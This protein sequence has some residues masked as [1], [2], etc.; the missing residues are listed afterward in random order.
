VR[1]ARNLADQASAAAAEASLNVERLRSSSAAIGSVVEVISKIAKQTTLLALNSTIEAAR[2]G[3]SGRGF[4]VVA[5]EVKA[6]AVQTQDATEEIRKKIEALQR[7][8]VASFEAVHRISSAINSIRPVFENVNTAVA[9]QSSVTADMVGNAAS[10][11]QFIASVSGSAIEIDGVTREAETHGVN[12][13]EV[14]QTV[15]QFAE[16]LKSRCAILLGR[17][18]SDDQ[19][20]HERL[21]CRINVE[22]ETR[23]GPVKTEIQEVSQIGMLIAEPKGRPIPLGDTVSAIADGI[24]R[25]RIRCVERTATGAGSSLCRPMRP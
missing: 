20:K 9:D 4:A 3:V 16:K 11:S 12:V 13:A 1:D 8:A 22:I 5:T 18:G 25:C 10:A 15:T 14:G 21:P 23:A 24:G 19:R 6:L 2:A 17:N 7:D